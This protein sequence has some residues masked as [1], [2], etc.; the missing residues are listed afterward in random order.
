[1]ISA[2]GWLGRW[3]PWKSFGR[4][5]LLPSCQPYPLCPFSPTP[6]LFTGYIV[7]SSHI[8]LIETDVDSVNGTGAATSGVAVGQGAST[9]TFKDIA[10]FAESYVFGILGQDA[11]G[12]INFTPTAS[13]LTS[14]G[15]FTATSTGSLTNGFNEAFFGGLFVNMIDTFQTP[16]CIL[17]NNGTGRLDCNLTYTAN[18]TGPEFVFYQTGN[19]NPPLILDVDS[20]LLGGSGAGAGFAYPISTPVSFSGDYGVRLTQMTLGSEADFT[21]QFNADQAAQTLAGTLDV[22]TGFVNPGPTAL[23][24]TFAPSSRPNVLSGTL[25]NPDQF[26]VAN[27]SGTGINVD[28]YFIDSSHGFFIETD[29]NDPINPSSSVAFGYFAARTSVS[30]RLPLIK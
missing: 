19:G 24:G 26:L 29:L 2:S 1:M 12:P 27:A 14:A 9:G 3:R 25:S 6:I 11:S 13:S 30:T 28:Y 17:D 23:T 22:N 20:N 21:G 8:K 5:R 7:D 10:A 15:T 4:R 18:G 16:P